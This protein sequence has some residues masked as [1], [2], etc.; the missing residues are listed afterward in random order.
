MFDIAELCMSPILKYARV[1]GLLQQDCIGK[2]HALSQWD[3]EG[4]GGTLALKT[5]QGD[6][7]CLSQL[8]SMVISS[9]CVFWS[10]DL[11]DLT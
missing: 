2:R 6:S 10:S 11:P 7:S 4:F 8:A 3:S 5:S 9:L 1:L